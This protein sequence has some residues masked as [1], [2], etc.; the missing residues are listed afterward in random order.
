MISEIV[1]NV[2]LGM[3]RISYYYG[4]PTGTI[5]FWGA[6]VQR[7]LSVDHA[8]KTKVFSAYFMYKFSRD[9]PVYNTVQLY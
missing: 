3:K 8:F 5:A 7:I 2:A 9:L 4:I 6:H 1:L